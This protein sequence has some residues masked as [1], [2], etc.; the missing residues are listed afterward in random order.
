MPCSSEG[1]RSSWLSAPRKPMARLA[2]K[3][4]QMVRWMLTPAALMALSS[5]LR[6]RRASAISAASNVTTGRNWPRRTGIW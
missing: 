4:G 6:A 2:M 3:T 5:L 1:T